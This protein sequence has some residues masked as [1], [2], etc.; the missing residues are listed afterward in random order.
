MQYTKGHIKRAILARLDD[1]DVLI[2]KVEGAPTK[3]DLFMENSPSRR[4][5]SDSV[6]ISV[7]MLKWRKD[8]LMTFCRTNGVTATI[9][10]NLFADEL[11][12]NEY[13]L[14]LRKE[15]ITLANAFKHHF[16]GDTRSGEGN[17]ERRQF[18]L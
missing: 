3:E 4:Y 13:S 15:M 5:E 10:I 11:V 2:D 18:D 1:G 14:P 17:I 16:V 8:R 7:R 6:L 9:L 12:Y